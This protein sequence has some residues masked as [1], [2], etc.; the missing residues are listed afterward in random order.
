[1]P[2]QLD[3]HFLETIFPGK[4]KNKILRWC[5]TLQKQELDT[6]EDLSLLTDDYDWKRL[7]L[8][9]KVEKSLRSAAARIIWERGA[10]EGGAGAKASVPASIS[11]DWVCPICTFVNSDV[12]EC[13]MCATTRI[14]TEVTVPSNN[15]WA[16]L[17]TSTV[18]RTP[19]NQSVRREQTENTRPANVETLRE[20]GATLVNTRQDLQRNFPA[21]YKLWSIST[22]YSQQQIDAF[23]ASEPYRNCPSAE[24]WIVPFRLENPHCC[25]RLNHRA[26]HG[27]SQTSCTYNHECLLCGARHGMWQQQSNRKYRCALFQQYIEEAA[28]HHL[29]DHQIEALFYSARHPTRAA[30]TAPQSRALTQSAAQMK[31]SVGPDS[32]LRPGRTNTKPMAA[33]DLELQL[34]GGR[35]T[36]STSGEFTTSGAPPDFQASNGNDAIA[37]DLA[38]KPEP[39]EHLCVVCFEEPREIALIPCGHRHL[40]AF[41]A[42]KVT[43][44]PTCRKEVQ[45]RLS[46][47]L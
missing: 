15:P 7:G 9:I 14:G 28:Q 23:T 34:L 31:P 35:Y 36:Y 21:T 47:Y 20:P 42:D 43:A 37:P 5:D 39:D 44:C 46:V 16:C 17:D 25:L 40:C 6:L 10:G 8:P 30:T 12:A 3:T 19:E 22:K 45:G 27:C 11:R 4:P 32:R 33:E 26:G 2:T 18:I 24:D 41:C 29:E 38:R 1:M 13:H